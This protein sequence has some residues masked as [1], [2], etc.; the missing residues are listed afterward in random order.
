[1][2]LAYCVYD[3]SQIAIGRNWCLPSR[4]TKNL[5]SKRGSQSLTVDS[6]FASLALIS[7]RLLQTSNHT[8]T[9]ALIIGDRVMEVFTF[10]SFFFLSF[11]SF[12]ATPS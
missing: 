11:S 6:S 4:G 9:A 5:R 1:M 7:V 2:V 12:V 3:V 8:R 10:L